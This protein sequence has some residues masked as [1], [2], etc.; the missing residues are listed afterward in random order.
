MRA[1]RR[2]L[3]SKGMPRSTAWAGPF[4]LIRT[5]LARHARVPHV[6]RMPP[7]TAMGMSFRAHSDAPARHARGPHLERMPP[8]TAW[9]ASLVSTDARIDG[10]RHVRWC[11][12]RRRCATRIRVAPAHAPRPRRRHSHAHCAHRAAA[13]AGC[14][15]LLQFIRARPTRRDRPPRS[16]ADPHAAKDVAHDGARGP[17]QADQDGR[18]GLRRRHC[19]IPR[20]EGNAV[21]ARMRA[22]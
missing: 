14:P 21:A 5:P 10:K 16:T 12:R 18:P 15:R 13:S 11:Q 1:I 2:S 7:S 6:K 22:T 4:A 19:A 8:S 20:N 3:T 17:V 9:G